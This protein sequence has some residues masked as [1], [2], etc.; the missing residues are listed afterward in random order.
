MVRNYI[1]QT[2]RGKTTQDSMKEAVDKVVV[3]KQSMNSVAKSSGI[4]YSTLRKYCLIQQENAELDVHVGYHTATIFTKEQEQLLVQYLLRAS[5]MY[6]GLCL[7][8]VKSL[9][10]EY[11][12]KL[13]I[14]MP[15]SWGERGFASKDWMTNFI[16]RHPELTLRSP[17]ATSLSRVTSFNRYN[18]NQFFD[19]YV[20][21]LERT[22]FTP[23]Q[24]WNLDETGCTT[25]Q[26]PNKVLAAR[27]V[28]QVGAIVSAERGQLVTLC[29]AV[30]AMGNTIPPMF[31]FPRVH[32]NKR[33]LHG[34]PIGSIC[35]A[36]PS[37]WMTSNTF[38]VFMKHF[39]KYSHAS[40]DRKVLLLLDNHESHISVQTIELAKANGVVMLS[41]P[42]HCSH[43]LQ[44][45]DRSVYGPFKRYYNSACDMCM[46]NHPGETM[47]IYEIAEM[48][49]HAFPKAMTPHNIQS[50]FRVSGI[51]PVNPDIF[52]DDEFLPSEVTDRPLPDQHPP[53]VPEQPSAVSH[54][55]A[56]VSQQPAAV[57]QEPAAR[58]DSPL[59]K[60]TTVSASTSVHRT[61][62]PDQV[63]PFKK[64][65]PRKK[66][67]I[68]RKKGSTRILT[69]TPE[70]IKNAMERERTRLPSPE[71]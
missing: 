46:L 12:T 40:I 51:Q 47:T 58:L 44:P 45:L 39:I 19:N 22:H 36:Y 31:V 14:T 56:A 16:K 35:E 54:Q 62:T 55:P 11:G 25:V 3:Q 20:K 60:Q 41:F 49:G 21:V 29:C 43:K 28:K 4:A 9:A 6:F 23:D 67:K 71:L 61:I 68:A 8:E 52:T 34:A 30:N 64:A 32:F 50:G 59:T 7:K 2:E 65:A 66:Q 57:S 24:I 38:L 53:A 17:E 27:G 13:E 42:P 63:R 70:K 15:I 1:R 18:V 10:F 37:G 5:A 26:K 69:D 48:V 33:F